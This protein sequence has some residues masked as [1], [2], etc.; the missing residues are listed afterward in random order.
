MVSQIYFRAQK[1]YYGC[2]IIS[3]WLLIQNYALKDISS[4]EFLKIQKYISSSLEV[5]EYVYKL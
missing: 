2:D 4:F 5:D 3:V 1:E